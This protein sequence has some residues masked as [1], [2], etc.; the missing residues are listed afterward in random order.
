MHGARNRIRRMSSLQLPEDK[1]KLKE[2]LSKDEYTAYSQTSHNS[3]WDLLSWVWR[4]MRGLFPDFT[5]SKGTGTLISYILIAIALVLV[6]LAIYWFFK[7]IVRQSHIRSSSFL[8]EGESSRSYA[9][10]WQQAA[11]YGDAGAW[12]EG[13]RSVFLT[14]LFY[15][16]AQKRIRVESWK[17]NW[18]YAAELAGTDPAWVQL[19]HDCSLL[20]DRIW[21]GNAE[22]T[23]QVFSSIFD[24]VAVLL[25][26]EAEKRHANA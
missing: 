22:A 6:S 21:Y 7:Q 1:E 2:I 25:E 10:Y 26:K 16:E 8:P 20:F 13:V 23:E 4:K 18:E 11:E 9:Y 24:S 14:L 15:L 12:R 19:F 17:T 5:V 3:F